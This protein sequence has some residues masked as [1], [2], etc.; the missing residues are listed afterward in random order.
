MTLSPPRITLDKAGRIQPGM[1]KAEVEAL[2]GPP[3][4]ESR[5]TAWELYLVKAVEAPFRFPRGVDQSR[6]DLHYWWA[7]DEVYIR[8]SW[9]KDDKVLWHHYCELD[10]S[11]WRR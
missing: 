2:L 9:D 11:L 8:V 6:G 10:V 7:S 4:N 1:T 5:H 3:R